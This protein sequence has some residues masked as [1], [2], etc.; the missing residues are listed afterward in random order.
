MPHCRSRGFAIYYETHGG[1]EGVPLL[2]L[3]GLGGTCHGWLLLQV[4]ELSK[5]RTNLIIDN[6][7]AGSSEDPGG[8]YT[9]RH[10]AEDALAVLDDLGVERAHVLGGFLGGLAAQELAIEH[11]DRVQSLV[12][13][14]SYA[15]PDAKRRMLLELLRTMVEH[16]LPPEA[17]I[18]YRMMWTLHDQTLEQADLIDAAFDFY[19]RDHAPVP[20]DVV[21]RQVNACLRHDTLDRLERIRCP[22]LVLHGEADQLTPAH[23]NRELAERIPEAR[24][25]TIPGAAHLVAAEA[26]PLFNQ[27]VAGFLRDNDAPSSRTRP[28]RIH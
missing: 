28:S 10:M 26:A 19:R 3:I 13:V 11:P 24:L 17:R 12:L 1:G 2:L 5:E 14:G 27:V 8:E 15:R 20:D 7:G 6:R 4:P 25:V 18:R 16:G 22:A 23:L 9:T 21:I